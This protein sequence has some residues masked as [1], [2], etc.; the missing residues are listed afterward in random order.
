M[1]GVAAGPVGVEALVIPASHHDRAPGA[2][3][4]AH[5]LAGPVSRRGPRVREPASPPVRPAPRLRQRRD[6]SLRSTRS[7]PGRAWRAPSR[8]ER[9]RYTT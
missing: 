5:R 2:S 8:S 6:G 7:H 3:D 1:V 4:A 9:E